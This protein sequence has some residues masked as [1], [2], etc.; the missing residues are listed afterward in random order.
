[1][2]AV[3]M[4]ESAAMLAALAQ[5]PAEPAP[6]AAVTQATAAAAAAAQTLAA[7][8][9]AA[10]AAAAHPIDALILAMSEEEAKA[11]KL[12]DMVSP[13]LP[14]VLTA[15]VTYPDFTYSGDCA[16]FGSWQRRIAEIMHENH[17][18]CLVPA[19]AA[20]VGA[21]VAS[22]FGRALPIHPHY[23]SL[24][25]AGVMAINAARKAALETLQSRAYNVLYRSLTE[26]LAVLLVEGSS[27]VG[28][29]PTALY[30]AIADH[31]RGPIAAA[32]GEQ[33]MQEFYGITWD[34]AA[35]KLVDQVNSFSVQIQRVIRMAQVL[36]D[37]YHISFQMA[38][39]MIVHKLPAALKA[40]VR[41]YNEQSDL[42]SLVMEIRR[43]AAILDNGA[44]A[45]MAVLT[46][47][48]DAMQRRLD[49]L[50]AKIERAM[51][52]MSSNRGGGGG[53]G[54]GGNGR[55][56]FTEAQ[57]M[58]KDFRPTD[59]SPWPFTKFCSHHGHSTTHS[60]D[61]CFYLHPELQR[62]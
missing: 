30:T 38:R 17:V 45:N 18:A 47:R 60:D 10:A 16:E 50:A 19:L 42:A 31:A 37:A 54:G 51:T 24:V 56:R 34:S 14:G 32:T 21:H 58:D 11:V 53:G 59:G 3:A 4:A 39:A 49:D 25:K 12:A 13:V 61:G 33:I 26:E 6:V 22:V 2:N 46:V 43:D 55:P 8:E 40:N 41:T 1:M 28:R 52:A 29:S 5:D 20:L 48:E 27:S 62:K 35:D 7:A 36:G 23:T 44:A 9:A 15:P 57:L